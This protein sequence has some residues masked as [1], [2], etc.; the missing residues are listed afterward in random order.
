MYYKPNDYVC[1]SMKIGITMS[2]AERY[3]MTYAEAA[4]LFNA[5]GIYEYLDKGAD[6][7]ISRMYPAMANRVAKKLGIPVRMGHDR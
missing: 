7:F 1:M 5:N 6:V 4:S 2:F 3:D